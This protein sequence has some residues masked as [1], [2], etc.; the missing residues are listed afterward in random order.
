MKMISIA[1]G[2]NLKKIRTYRGLSLDAVSEQTGVS[3]S[4]LRQI[5]HGTTN[6][7][8]S[9][10]WK[11]SNGLKIPYSSLLVIPQKEDNVIDKS[12]LTLITSDDQLYENIPF[13]RFDPTRNFEMFKVTIRPTGIV[14]SEPHPKGTFEYIIVFDGEIVVEYGDQTAIVRA[15]QAIKFAADVPHAY[16]NLGKNDASL[17]TVMCYQ[18]TVIPIYSSD[19]ILM[20]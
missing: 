1:L 9:T 17:A 4:M 7:T 2:E 5:E 14:R 20:D 16:Y 10:I 12:N 3:K 19:D 15:D 6:P 8:L 18:A 13:F 11:I